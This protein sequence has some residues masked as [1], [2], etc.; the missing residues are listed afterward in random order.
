MLHSVKS[1][2]LLDLALKISSSAVRFISFFFGL[3]PPAIIPNTGFSRE[4]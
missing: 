4:N 2:V 3:S 1:L